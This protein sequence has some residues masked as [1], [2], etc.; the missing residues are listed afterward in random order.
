MWP[1]IIGYVPGME[2]EGPREDEDEDKDKDKDDDEQIMT[3]IR[4]DY[5]VVRDRG[6][7]QFKL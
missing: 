4:V 6:V 2:D 1:L 3:T 7:S 5:L